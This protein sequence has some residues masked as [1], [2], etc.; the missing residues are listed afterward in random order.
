VPASAP[1]LGAVCDVVVDQH[2]SVKEFGCGAK[3]PQC[4]RKLRIAVGQTISKQQQSRADAF[5]WPDQVFSV[6]L[7]A[8]IQ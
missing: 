3:L 2:E 5:A 7:K 4:R 6:L 8:S 1:H